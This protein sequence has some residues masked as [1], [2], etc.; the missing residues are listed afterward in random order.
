MAAVPSANGLN[1]QPRAEI[2]H[3]AVIG[4][5]YSNLNRGALPWQRGIAAC[6]PC[7]YQVI[8]GK[9]S[10]QLNRFHAAFTPLRVLVALATIRLLV[11]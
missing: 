1:L 6:P 4:V 7:D 3:A 11:E 9:S 5:D 10:W 8:I 2:H